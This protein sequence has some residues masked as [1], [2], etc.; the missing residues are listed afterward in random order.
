M[1]MAIYYEGPNLE[2]P[3]S[4]SDTDDHGFKRISVYLIA[5]F[6]LSAIL[7]PL[8]PVPEL[9]REQQEKLPDNLARLLLEKKVIPEPIVEK[10]VIPKIEQEAEKEIPPEI[11]KEVEKKPQE[12]K[13]EPV[14]KE[15]VKEEPKPLAP[16]Q[17]AEQARQ[18]ASVSGLLQFKDDLQEMRDMLDVKSLKNKM[19][20]ADLR[21]TS[22][23]AIEVKRDI[24][25]SKVKAKSGGIQVDN[26]S[27]DAG[28]VALSGK[29]NTQVDSSLSLPGGLG[30]ETLYKEALNQQQGDKNGQLPSRSEEEMRRVMD[31]NKSAIFAIYNRALRSDPTLEGKLMVK[32]VID[33][34]GF[35]MASELIS[36][37]L[38][39]L[40]LEGKLLT[41]IKLIQFPAG[42]Y[43]LTTLNQTFDFLPF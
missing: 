35:V 26:I 36:S 21:R 16:A 34:S 13:Q 38:D 2:L 15:P 23:T 43:A 37:Q 9:A 6:V 10:P 39:N 22:A 27:V 12:I 30:S 32:I 17:L 4:V 41:R 25:A 11:I 28:G 5:V 42:E 14:K 18:R 8:L 29:E 7:V 40:D 24:I 19:A 3:W 1:N 33:A 20:S 31:A